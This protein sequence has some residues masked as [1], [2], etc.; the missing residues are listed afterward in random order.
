MIYTNEL[1]FIWNWHK[2]PSFTQDREK[3]SWKDVNIDVT[4]N[5]EGTGGSV[6][7]KVRKVKENSIEMEDP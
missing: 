6:S 2:S 5:I 1:P 3:L 7:K 4:I